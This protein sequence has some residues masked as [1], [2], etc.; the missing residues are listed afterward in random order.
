[1]LAEPPW[2][3]Q[4]LQVQFSS[5]QFLTVSAWFHV[6]PESEYP[7][8]KPGCEDPT[9]LTDLLLCKLVYPF[10]SSLQHL[11]HPAKVCWRG[12][13][14]S[15]MQWF[16]TRSVQWFQFLIRFCRLSTASITTQI[17]TS[18]N[19]RA[20]LMRKI[21]ARNAVPLNPRYPPIHWPTPYDAFADLI[22]TVRICKQWFTIIF[23]NHELSVHGNAPTTP[24]P[25]LATIWIAYGNQYNYWM[26]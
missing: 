26:K 2:L 24:I 25:Y 5:A 10:P 20:Y 15:L 16:V 9:V 6:S 12:T 22:S 21:K 13:H 7:L 14:S 19:L 23:P 1:M 11:A 3:A 18:Y 8:K 4:I 17:L